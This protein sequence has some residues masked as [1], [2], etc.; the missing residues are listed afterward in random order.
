MT[1]NASGS[2]IAVGQPQLTESD[3]ILDTLKARN[4]SLTWAVIT[5]CTIIC[6]GLGWF[7]WQRYLALP[8]EIESV[9]VSHIPSTYHEA[10]PGARFDT[11]HT[12][13]ETSIVTVTVCTRPG[14]TC[15]ASIQG[16][17]QQ[18]RCHP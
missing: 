18:A 4:R 1:N 14:A 10:R 12:T 9:G 3:K 8:L 16:Q 7:L 13:T 5:L 2:G 6:I 15:T 11:T 17:Q